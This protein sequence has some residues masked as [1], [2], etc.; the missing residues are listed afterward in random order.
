M[1][2]KVSLVGI[3]MVPTRDKDANLKRALSLADE[4]FST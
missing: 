1:E 4:A 3:Q 2:N